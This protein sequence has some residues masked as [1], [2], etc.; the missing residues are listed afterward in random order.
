MIRT[1]DQSPS[2][3][4][5]ASNGSAM[6][7]LLS[8]SWWMLA[9]RGVIAVLFGVLALMWPGITL[10]SLVLLFAAYALLSGTVSVAGAVIN[11]KIDKQWWMILLLG[12]VS[13]VAG[14]FA[15]TNPGLTALALVLLMGANAVVV[16]VLDIVVAARL[17]KT[18]GNEWLLILTG[19]VSVVFGVLVLLFPGAGA[20]A[21]VW[22]ISTYAIFTG[23][24]LLALAF[25]AQVWAKKSRRSAPLSGGQPMTEGSA[26][27]GPAAMG[28]H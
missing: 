7:D 8:R 4:I 28:K 21:L 5:A 14:I 25:R 12:L 27:T 26:A 6:D 20:L 9:L 17:R 1:T 18:R 22:L 16:G 15:V 3:N 11:R 24:L 19:V 10:L 2:G 23:I 13:I